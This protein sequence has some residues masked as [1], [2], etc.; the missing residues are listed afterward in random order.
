MASAK[1]REIRQKK[2]KETHADA[3]AF[4]DLPM[5]KW[6]MQTKSATS[7]PPRSSFS[8]PP[9]KSVESATTVA[10]TPQAPAKKVVPSLKKQLSHQASTLAVN[11]EIEK[12]I[13]ARDSNGTYTGHKVH[14]ETEMGKTLKS[15]RSQML[16]PEKR[17][18]LRRIR[19]M[20]AMMEKNLAEYKGIE[21]QILDHAF[22]DSQ[23]VSSQAQSRGLQGFQ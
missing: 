5:P 10:S 21:E 14:S 17:A 12:A 15:Q 4:L 20:I 3:Q 16:S 6:V 19:D 2:K 8:P 22:S 18:E 9:R 13:K 23:S 7:K 1:A 11:G